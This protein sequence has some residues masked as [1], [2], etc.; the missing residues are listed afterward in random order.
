MSRTVMLGVP[1]TGQLK[2]LKEYSNSWLSAPLVWTFLSEKYF[3]KKHPVG[4]GEQLEEIFPMAEDEKSPM[5]KHE[6]DIL[7]LT[8]DKMVLPREH[9]NRAEQSLRAMWAATHN[10]NHR[11]NHLLTIADDLKEVPQEFIGVCFIWTT[12]DGDAWVVEDDD[13]DG[14]RFYDIS[15]D[16]GHWFLF[17]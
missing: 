12:V 10:P 7:L 4:L 13:A 9:F 5:L 15:K 2:I 8:A 17:R 14:H 3:P 16:T 6:K 11:G 1:E